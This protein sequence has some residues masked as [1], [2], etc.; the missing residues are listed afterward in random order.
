MF[1]FRSICCNY[2]CCCFLENC[3]QNNSQSTAN[4]FSAHLQPRITF[5]LSVVQIIT[6]SYLIWSKELAETFSS[7]KKKSESLITRIPT[8]GRLGG[9]NFIDIQNFLY[10]RD[11]DSNKPSILFYHLCIARVARVNVPKRKSI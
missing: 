6:R 3:H 9:L 11:Q 4:I 2:F 8:L 1:C 5:H 10:C 7:L